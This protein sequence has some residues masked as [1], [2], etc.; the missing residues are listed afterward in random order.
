MS[1]SQLVLLR[2][3]RVWRQVK[4]RP[5]H[6]LDTGHVDR[7]APQRVRDVFHDLIR[8]RNTFPRKR[9]LRLLSRGLLRP[10]LLLQIRGKNHINDRFGSLRWRRGR[11]RLGVEQRRLFALCHIAE[12]VKLS[13]RFLVFFG[14]LFP[15]KGT[16]GLVQI[17]RPLAGFGLSI[18]QRFIIV[19]I[20]H[21]GLPRLALCPFPRLRQ[22]ALRLQHLFGQ[23][24]KQGILA[25]HIKAHVPQRNTERVVMREVGAQR[26]PSVEHLVVQLFR[27]CGIFQN[28]ENGLDAFL[29]VPCAVHLRRGIRIIL[30]HIDVSRQHLHLIGVEI[31]LLL[32]VEIPSVVDQLPDT[33]IDLIPVHRYGVVSTKAGGVIAAAIAD[34]FGIVPLVVAHSAKAAIPILPTH[35]IR[36][37]FGVVPLQNVRE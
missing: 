30:E 4:N 12:Q 27:L 35:I 34:A 17:D 31:P 23:G 28:G 29:Y 3:F 9:F 7:V 5:R 13:A 20:D 37:L 8:H 10:V 33:L 19:V 36:A 32:F 18:V 21:T 1:V 22:V 14:F 26:H 15:C 11:F 16:G 6:F 2:S 24:L 25:P